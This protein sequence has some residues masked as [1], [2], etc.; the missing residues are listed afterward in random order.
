[1]KKELRHT[2]KNYPF[3]L[4]LRKEGWFVHKFNKDI[5]IRAY[6]KGRKTTRRETL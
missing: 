5:L 2:F 1:M 6:L 4:E 3:L